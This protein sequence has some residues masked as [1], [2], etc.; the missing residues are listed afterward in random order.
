VGNVGL[1]GTFLIVTL[2]TSITFLTALSIAEIASDQRVRVGGAYYMISRSLGI[3]TGGAV[4]IPLYLAQALSV[5]LYTVGFAESVVRVFPALDER[6]IGLITTLLVALLALKSARVAIRAQYVIMVAIALSLLSFVFGHAVEPAAV[7]ESAAALSG[8]AT[9]APQVI[10]AESFWLVFAVFFPAV[11]GIMTGVN[12][13]GDLRQPGRSIPRGTLAAVGVGY[14]VYMG[15]PFLLASRADSATLIAE[16]F[17]MRRMA[18]FGDLIIAGVWGATLSS[19]VGSIL[20]AP[21]V[22]QALARDGVLPR[23]MRWLGKGNAEDDAPRNGTLFTLGIAL[24]AV[25]FGNL[26]LIAPVLTMFFLTTYGVL[27]ISAA[28]ER[29][30]GSPSFRPKFRVHWALSALGAVGCGGVMF[31]IN[32][33]ATLAAAVIVGG[34]YVWLERRELRTTWGDI[35]RGMWMAITRAGLF[36]LRGITD[37]RNWRPHLLV[38]SGS[39]TKRWHLIALADAL[40]H[41]RAFVTVSSVLTDPSVTQERQRAMEATLADYLA[42]RGVRALTRLIRAPTAFEGAERL[43]EAYG[44][45]ALVPNTMLLGASESEEHREDYSA[46][47]TKFHAARRNVVVLHHN[48][49][50]GFGQQKRID[51]WWGGFKRNGGLMM[52]LAY[53]LQTSVPWRGAHLRIKMVV[54]TEAAAES[55]RDNL[56]AIIRNLRTPVSPEVIVSDGRPFDQILSAS[57]AHSDLIFM[58]MRVPDE[59]GYAEYLAGL[60]QQVYRLPSTAFVLAAE[61]LQFSD[62]LFAGDREEE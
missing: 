30:L 42:R 24:A 18:L 50:L 57:S 15:L 31:L 51:V 11:T 1:A 62:I 61:D 7:A 23:S 8:G 19:A 32:P 22:L 56:S 36:R 16:P 5:A 27:N 47:L 40:S 37:A 48:E 43:M 10:R 4:G 6:I 34:I 25:W 54:P 33:L 20:G 45:G 2:A 9:G 26:N 21:R 39:P 55:A 29:F 52:T 59:D 3:E 38:L 44:I 17:V 14:L 58:G 46:M 41:N 28:T 53:L 60:R 49:V 12:M 13:S 35:R